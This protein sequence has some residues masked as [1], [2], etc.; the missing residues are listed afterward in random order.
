MTTRD[1][2]KAFEKHR[3]KSTIIRTPLSS[4]VL[5]PEIPAWI[6]IHDKVNINLKDIDQILTKLNNV[7]SSRKQMIFS[8]SKELK[9]TDAEIDNSTL[10]IQFLLNKTGALIQSVATVGIVKELTY[11]ERTCRVNVIQALALKLQRLSV[12]YRTSSQ[13]YLSFI[14][15]YENIPEEIENNDIVFEFQPLDGQE[16]TI[17]NAHKHNVRH[18]EI[19]K[20]ANSINQVNMLSKEINSLVVVQGS[21]LDNIDYNLEQTA[22]QTAKALQHLIKLEKKY[23][24]SPWLYCIVFLMFVILL[25]TVIL[26][27]K[28]S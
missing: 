7:Y 20:L 24:V 28:K 5:L 12:S 11:V 22:K 27:I 6:E 3:S 14:Q 2:T 26:I 21:C 23:K 15:K 18:Q 16:M 10:A 1:L 4:T 17:G 9:Q 13:S 25:F 19:K 8:S